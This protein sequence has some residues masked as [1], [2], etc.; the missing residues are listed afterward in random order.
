MNDEKTSL[1]SGFAE[2]G[3]WPAARRQSIA[4]RR[5]LFQ[6]GTELFLICNLSLFVSV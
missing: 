6:L 4:A 1:Y 2:R 3:G 5:N